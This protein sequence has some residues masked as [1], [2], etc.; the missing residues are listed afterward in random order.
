MP[1]IWKTNP[2]TTSPTGGACGACQALAGNPDGQGWRSELGP[3]L[4][5]WEKDAAG[6]WQR[7]DTAGYAGL[8]PLHPNCRCEIINVDPGF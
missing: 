6:N 2:D 1:L 7:R 5:L 3:E 8:P 4:D